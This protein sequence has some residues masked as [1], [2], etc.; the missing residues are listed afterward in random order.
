MISHI[1]QANF[2]KYISYLA[3]ATFVTISCGCS[4]PAPMPPPFQEMTQLEVRELQS[5]EFNGVKIEKVMKAVVSA[6]QD[7]GFIISNADSTLGIITAALEIYEEDKATKDWLKFN[8]GGGVGTYQTTKRIETSSNIREYGG[9]IRVRINI[10]AKA[11]SNTG[12]IIWSQPVQDAQVYQ[13][14]FAKIN[15]AVFLEKQNL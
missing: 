15:K 9:K 6:L 11:L 7:E 3:I 10:V 4:P 8:Y 5:R 13:N 1:M 12:G 2:K 14:I